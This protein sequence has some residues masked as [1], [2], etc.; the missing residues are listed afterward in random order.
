MLLLRPRQLT[1]IVPINASA[2]RCGPARHERNPEGLPGWL[3]RPRRHAQRPTQRRPAGI[4][5][6]LRSLCRRRLTGGAGNCV[7]QSRQQV[8]REP[9]LREGFELATAVSGL[10]CVAR[11][12]ECVP[13]VLVLEPQLLWGGG[14]GVLAMMCEV[15]QLVTV[16]VMV[17][18]TCRDP[19]VLNP[20]ARFPIS[21]YHR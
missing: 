12:R 17:L 1:Q 6:D 20:V 21:D 16:P 19:L 18:T 10:E 4:P 15:P 11:L 2:A 7:G 9:L 8:R 13:D 3:A 14:D 5:E